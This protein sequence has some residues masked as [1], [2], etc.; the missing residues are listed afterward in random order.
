MLNFT[1]KMRQKLHLKTWENKFNVIVTIHNAT[2][3]SCERETLK[4]HFPR[5]F[6]FIHL[7]EHH[8]KT[9]RKKMNDKPETDVNLHF[10]SDG[11]KNCEAFLNFW[12]VDRRLE[13]HIVVVVCYKYFLD[14]TETHPILWLFE[15]TR[16][17]AIKFLYHGAYLRKS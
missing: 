7:C 16:T 4:C 6:K 11:E 2:W 1:E 13:G 5:I 3:A 9:G 12:K 17:V 10:P 14:K 15:I 8:F